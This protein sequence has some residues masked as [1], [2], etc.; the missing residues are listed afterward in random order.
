MFFILLLTPSTR[1][2]DFPRAISGSRPFAS[3]LLFVPYIVGS[4]SI[5]YGVAGGHTPRTVCKIS[6]R[7]WVATLYMLTQ[8]AEASTILFLMASQNMDYSDLK[9][10]AV[11]KFG[12]SM[13][14]GQNLDLEAG[15]PCSS[16]QLQDLIDANKAL[17]ETISDFTRLLRNADVVSPHDLLWHTKSIRRARKQA[18]VVHFLSPP[19]DFLPVCHFPDSDIGREEFYAGR[20][21]HNFKRC[22]IR[23]LKLRSRSLD[24]ILRVH[25]VC[26]HC[27][28][29]GRRAA[30]T[31]AMARGLLLPGPT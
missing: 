11:V 20:W 22:E 27:V 30:R 15:S 26:R 28:L 31:S 9:Q 18:A 10:M 21:Q 23:R 3:W 17:N 5:Y 13:L 12:S 29:P 14:N 7:T 8:R 24:V 2:P 1:A 25:S 4:P 16:L 6:M 19:I